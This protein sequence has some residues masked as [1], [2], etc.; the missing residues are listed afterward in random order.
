MN[1]RKYMI[2]GEEYWEDEEILQFYN[3]KNIPNKISLR[4]AIITK[5]K[6]RNNL[7]HR[8]VSKI[9][10]YNNKR[11]EPWIF[12]KRYLPKFIGR[13]YE[14]TEGFF[15]KHL[16]SK[17]F[18]WFT[19]EF[20]TEN[21]NT[22]WD[23]YYNYLVGSNGIIYKNT[24]KES[25]VRYVPGTELQA[26]NKYTGEK[27]VKVDQKF[28]WKWDKKSRIEVT[29]STGSRKAIKETALEYIDNRVQVT[30]KND[31]RYVRAN[32]EIQQAKRKAERSKL[33]DKSYDVAL[34]QHKQKQRYKKKMNNYVKRLTKE[35]LEHKKIIIAVDFDSTLCHYPT[36]INPKDIERCIKLVKRA[37][38]IGAYVVLNT[39]SHEDRYLELIDYCTQLGIRVDDINKT[40]IKMPYSDTKKVYANI[41]LDDRAGFKEAMDILEIAMV[42][43]QPGN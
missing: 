31:Y 37:Q 2:Y 38:S 15:M 11:I 6:I 13:H 42:Q 29:T 21:S 30:S 10:K 35:W 19:R 26:I 1:P 33:V 23:K 16:G 8:S 20:R 9:V 25:K 17:Y 27:Y 41:Y 14:D 3:L 34:F 36:I 40:P 12:V 43:F 32:Y 22:Y 4:K 28:T 5:H 7:Y 24:Q 39:A 18:W